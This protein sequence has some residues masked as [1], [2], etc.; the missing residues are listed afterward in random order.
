MLTYLVKSD[1]SFLLTVADRA[2]NKITD[3]PALT[4]FAQNHTNYGIREKAAKKIKDES[5]LI[6]IAKNDNDEYV[7]S[8]AVKNRFETKLPFGCKRN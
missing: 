8:T 1:N 7:R 2:I 6:N 5:V 3:Q 4:F